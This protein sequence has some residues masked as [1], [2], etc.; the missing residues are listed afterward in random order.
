MFID[1]LLG[2]AP[3]METLHQQY[4]KWKK[5]DESGS[6]LYYFFYVKCP[7]KVK[8]HVSDEQTL[9]LS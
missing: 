4:I 3:V 6:I 5:S 2:I 7:E 8:N 1:T 9:R